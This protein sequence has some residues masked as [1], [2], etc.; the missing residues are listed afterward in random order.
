MSYKSKFRIL[1]VVNGVFLIA[2][3]LF[4]TPW[5]KGEK[6]KAEVGP[7]KY[8]AATPA[9]INEV[10]TRIKAVA[11]SDPRGLALQRLLQVA[12]FVC[13]RTF[14]EEVSS[15][16]QELWD[17]GSFPGVDAMVG[18]AYDYQVFGVWSVGFGVDQNDRIHGPVRVSNGSRIT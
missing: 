8:F 17:R 10:N 13:K 2:A 12:G 14:R 4:L 3:T 18:C 6:A 15:G 16:E 9:G 7:F 5:H 11:A 1:V